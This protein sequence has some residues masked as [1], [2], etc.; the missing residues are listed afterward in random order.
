MASHPKQ[1][2]RRN[3]VRK[4]IAAIAILAFL[5]LWIWLAGTIGSHMT[6]MSGWLQLVFY[7]VA[8]FAW[9]FPLRP[10]LKWMNSPQR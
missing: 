6:G 9:V 4:V 7:I 2:S 8:G 5:A 10:I 1:Q 3:Q